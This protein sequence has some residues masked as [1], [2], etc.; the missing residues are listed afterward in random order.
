MFLSLFRRCI[1]WT[2]RRESFLIEEKYRWRNKSLLD[3]TICEV[4]YHNQM[5]V[6]AS[7]KLEGFS[8]TD[9]PGERLNENVTVNVF[10]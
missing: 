4:I 2:P 5:S 3:R 1:S 9:V 10:L 6:S 7:Y 8:G